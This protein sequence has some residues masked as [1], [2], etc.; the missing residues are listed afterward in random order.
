MLDDELLNEPLCSH[1][2]WMLGLRLNP[3]V[4]NCCAGQS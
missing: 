2:R 3:M 4:Y 1:V